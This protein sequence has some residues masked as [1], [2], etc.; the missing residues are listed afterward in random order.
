MEII[1]GFFAAK[2]LAIA[3]VG[4]FGMVLNYILKNYVTTG[5][6]QWLGKKSKNL[7]Y[8]L[9]VFVTAGL[10]KWKYTSKLWNAIIEPYVVLIIH[11]LAL[12]F[13][14]FID[15]LASDNPSFNDD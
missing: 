12:I 8:A 11:Q 10:S 14:G 13:D 9:G 1:I 2:G 6:M 7:G 15:G 3:G 5:H 4:L